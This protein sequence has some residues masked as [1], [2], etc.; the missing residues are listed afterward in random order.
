MSYWLTSMDKKVHQRAMNKLI[1]TLNKTLE[2]DDLWCGRFTVCQVYSPEWRRY[3]DGSG[4]ELFVHLKFVDRA[5]G[6]YYISAN[7][8]NYWRGYNGSGW[9]LYEKLNWLIVTHWPIWQEP[10]AQDRN[11]PAWSEYNKNTRVC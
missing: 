3:E 5:T 9:R 10:L 4:A 6:R 8:V 11:F 2:K 1:R 7:T